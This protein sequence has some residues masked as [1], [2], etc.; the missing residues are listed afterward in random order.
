VHNAW[1][2]G[3]SIL[4]ALITGWMLR[5]AAPLSKTLGKTGLNIAVRLMGLLLSAAAV[6]I[7][8]HGLVQLFPKLL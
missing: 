7:M 4:V 5:L 1:L 3:I 8:A 6:Q 2:I